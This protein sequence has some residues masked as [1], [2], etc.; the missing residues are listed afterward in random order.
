MYKTP[1]ARVNNNYLNI[2]QGEEGV[3]GG[4]EGGR[5]TIPTRPSSHPL[6]LFPPHLFH[7]LIWNKLTFGYSVCVCTLYMC[8][9]YYIII[10]LLFPL[11]AI[12]VIFSCFYCAVVSR[13]AG[14]WR[15]I[16]FNLIHFNLVAI[17]FRRSYLIWRNSVIV[18][19]VGGFDLMNTKVFSNIVSTSLDIRNCQGSRAD[20]LMNTKVFSNI[21]S[22]SLDIH[23]FQGSRADLIWWTLKYFQT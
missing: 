2:F 12:I 8:A 14:L 9:S 22:T 19:G 5:G 7:T 20:T 10:L 13:I 6:S 21:V 16:F 11:H 3:K 4:G 18:R 17:Y 23:N 15:Y 1:G